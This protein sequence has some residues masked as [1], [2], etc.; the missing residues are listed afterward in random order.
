[1]KSKVTPTNQRSCLVPALAEQCDPWQ[2]LKRQADAIAWKTFEI[3]F[4]FL[5]SYTG[6]SAEPVR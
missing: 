5:Y 2:S 4:A 3:A 6:R 1:M